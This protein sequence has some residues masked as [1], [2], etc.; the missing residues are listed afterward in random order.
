MSEEPDE[1]EWVSDSDLGLAHLSFWYQGSFFPICNIPIDGYAN[2]TWAKGKPQCSVCQDI[3][4]KKL[5][6]HF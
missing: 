5:E 3:A 4:D 2:R 1:L 6:P